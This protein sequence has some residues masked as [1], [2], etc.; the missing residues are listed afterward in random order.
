MR[1]KISLL[2]LMEMTFQRPATNRQLTFHEIADQ[3]R[4]P[5]NEVE[6]LV[7]KALSLGLV[8]GSID[9][10]DQKV[11]MTWVQPRV[12]DLQQIATMQKRLEQWTEDVTGMEQLLE[13]KAKDIL[14]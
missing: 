8:K 6:M 5:N 11:H 13:V 3:T 9:E 14:T 12:L 4:L 10:I 7:M 2:C 1:Q